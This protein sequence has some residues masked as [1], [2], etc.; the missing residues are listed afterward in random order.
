LHH[1]AGKCIEY[2]DSWGFYAWHGVGVS[3]KV[4]LAPQ[5]LTARDFFRAPD[6]EVRRVIQER[7]G[8]R[9]ASVVGKNIIDSG[10]RGVHYEVNPPG[11]RDRR[12]RYVKVRNA[13][14]AREYYLRVPPT[15]STA[16]AAVAWTLGLTAAEYQPEQE[17]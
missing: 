6:L 11:D 4:I 15:I 12:A 13:S 5:N 17:S 9:F 16:E 14:T 10:P 3:R 2:P 8:E 1:A 7:M